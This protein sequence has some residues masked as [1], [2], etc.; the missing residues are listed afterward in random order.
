M[1]D[2]KLYSSDDLYHQYKIYND[3]GHYVA[4]KVKEKQGKKTLGVREK[5]A[6]E[7]VFDELYIYCIN[8]NI[9]GNDMIYYILCQFKERFGIEYEW[10]TQFIKDNIK[11][12][13]NNFHK[14]VKRFK[15]KAH[16][17]KWNYFVTFT[18]DDKLTNAEDF[19]RKLRKCLSNL[20]CRKGWRYM[21]VFEYGGNN[22]R[23]HFH[24]LLYVPN[25]EMVGEIFEKKRW[26]TKKH[27]ME[28]IYC[29]TFFS[30]RF[31]DSDFKQVSCNEM[32]INYILKYLHKT[33]EKIVYSRG[34]PSEIVKTI[35]D[36]D[37]A[38]EFL[39]FVVKYVLYDDAISYDSDLEKVDYTTLLLT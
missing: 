6:L 10:L 39:D 29:N 16:L 2:L 8:N 28:T 7:C 36:E 23:L 31:G 25:G 4:T 26:S 22:E 30:K 19:R 21:G 11:R 37:I 5:N 34:V 14:R 17:N 27:K 38:T 18:Y 9:S 33:N 13:L 24:C 1:Q 12:K 20:H 32:T 35:C 15:R 3:G